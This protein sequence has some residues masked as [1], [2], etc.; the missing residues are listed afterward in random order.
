[1]SHLDTYIEALENKIKE[2][3]GKIQQSIMNHNALLGVLAGTKEALGLT[4]EIVEKVAPDSSLDDVL[5]V[6]EE[7]V[8]VLEN[9]TH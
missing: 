5:N 7:V 4:H 2:Y 1:M 6:A 3:E 8:N 9:A